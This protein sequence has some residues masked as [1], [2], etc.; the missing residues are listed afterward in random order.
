MVD[1]K[2]TRYSLL[3]A[4]VALTA[5][6][7][8]LHHAQI[9]GLHPCDHKHEAHVHVG[10]HYAQCAN[11][12]IVERQ[13]A[14]TSDS[15]DCGSDHEKSETNISGLDGLAYKPKANLTVIETESSDHACDGTC[16]VC[17]FFAS[18]SFHA[19]VIACAPINEL[20][21]SIAFAA[22]VTQSHAIKH[23][24]FERGP[25]AFFPIA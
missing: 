20:S 4:F 3:L 21:H 19:A 24:Y 5:G 8:A 13:D 2:T 7:P 12:A 6:G 1:S 18:I 23:S 10:E 9:F 22:S 17:Q 25:P 16:S 11:P 15:C 14:G